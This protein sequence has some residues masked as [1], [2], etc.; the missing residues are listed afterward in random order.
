MK[1]Y[2]GVREAWAHLGYQ[3]GG[4]DRPTGMGSSTEVQGLELNPKP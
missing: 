4:E 3:A 1:K 2:G